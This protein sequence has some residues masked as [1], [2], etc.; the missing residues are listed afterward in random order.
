[1]TGERSGQVKPVFDAA[2][3]LEPE[4]RPA[5]LAALDSDLLKKSKRSSPQK[6]DSFRDKTPPG[7]HSVAPETAEEP[8][9]IRPSNAGIETPDRI[10][11]YPILREIG[12]GG[13][14]VVYDAVP[15]GVYE[16]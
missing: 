16:L 15:G 1:M 8:T 13:M 9:R 4:Q 3:M 6:D 10:G 14:G 2:S 12:E 7:M 5:F 11:P